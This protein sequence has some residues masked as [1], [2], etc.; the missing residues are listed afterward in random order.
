MTLQECPPETKINV[1][2]RP[3]Q[4]VE[5]LDKEAP[6]NT[7]RS[8]TTWTP[9][10]DRFF[11]E[12]MMEQVHKGY[13]N[14]TIFR[15][16]AWRNMV[17]L[18]NKKFG[19][20]VEKDVL[21]NR[22]KKI[23]LRYYAMK[24]LLDHGGFRWDD[25][26]QM[27]TADDHVWDDYIKVH[28]EARPYRTMTVPDYK[29]L[30]VI[31]G[32]E[33]ANGRYNSSG[34]SA[35]LAN[36]II[37]VKIGGESGGSQSPTISATHGDQSVSSQLIEGIN[38]HETT[39]STDRSKTNWTPPMDRCFIE[40]MLEQ[41]RRGYHT[42]NTFRKEAW[43]H[44]LELFNLKFGL[45][46]DKETLRNRFRKLRMQYNALKIILDQNGFCWDETRQMVVADDLV[47]DNYL[48]AH[49]EARLY[50]TKTVPNYNDLCMI[51]G[52]SNGGKRHS[53]SSLNMDFNNNSGTMIVASGDPV[54]DVQES[55]SHSGGG[56][57]TSNQLG[58]RPSVEPLNSQD[59]RKTQRSTNEGMVDALRQMAVAVTSL[60]NIK[61]ENESSIS[62]EHV[63][64]AL[65]AVPDMD[66][67]LFLDA[68]DL[69]EDEQKAKMFLALDITIRK[70]WL[71]RKLRP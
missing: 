5:G 55:S 20:G 56:V 69:L 71:M 26:R 54:V 30:S 19:L 41:V 46:L 36:E 32:N 28:P 60:A 37:E 62:C 4:V 66:E 15:K 49:P 2:I 42:G 8:R 3:S 63:V 22:L 1:L 7:D 35:D 39:P 23:R 31:F 21:K 68:C 10:M 65:K 45:Q 59:S 16:K 53:F 27:V 52:K 67:D 44:M 25:T 43:A 33:N 18:F 29:N 61:K 24:Y 58:K 64:N 70:K 11:I 50:R 38:N 34:R 17:T 48:K 14:N 51:Y 6:G 13:K 57:D 40:I 12:I 47:W 9:T